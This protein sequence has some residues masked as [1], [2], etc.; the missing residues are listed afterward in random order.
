MVC[1]QMFNNQLSAGSGW[2]VASANFC[3]VTAAIMADFKF[4]WCLSVN[5]MLRRDV[6]QQMGIEYFHQTDTIEKNNRK[7]IDNNK[8]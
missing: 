2:L 5:T 4:I 1:R 8:M 7:N 6:Q 3:A